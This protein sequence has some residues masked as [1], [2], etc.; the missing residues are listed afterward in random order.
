MKNEPFDKD[1]AM[2][3][4]LGFYSLVTGFVVMYIKNKRI[5]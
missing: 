5:I 3:R 1:T 2:Y 4:K